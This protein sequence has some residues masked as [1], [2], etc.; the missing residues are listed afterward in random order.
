[1]SYVLEYDTSIGIKGQLEMNIDVNP[2]ETVV[3]PRIFSEMT[4][5]NEFVSISQDSDNW[6]KL[7]GI[8]A[9]GK[10]YVSERFVLNL[11]DEECKRYSQCKDIQNR[12]TN[13]HQNSV[14]KVVLTL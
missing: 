10:V 2:G 14:G 9:N 13:K 12:F 7:I 4:E 11:N 8:T 1:M 6:L 5:R 3:L